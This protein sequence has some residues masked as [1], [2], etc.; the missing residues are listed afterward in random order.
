MTKLNIIGHMQGTSGYASHTRQ[1][2]NALYKLNP[3]VSLKA[4]LFPGYE[5]QL[6]NDELLMVEQET[7][8]DADILAI[9]MPPQ[10]P[11]GLCND[12]S[13]FIGYCVWEGSN[14]PVDWLYYFADDRVSNI[15]VPSNHTKQSI[16]NT[17][18]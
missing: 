15:I 9:T 3:E 6:N 11:V 2:V 18:N 8:K 10:W 4:Q 14:V 7:F 12:N 5:K 17:L 13:K 16:I 1:L